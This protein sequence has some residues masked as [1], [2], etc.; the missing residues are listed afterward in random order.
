MKQLFFYILVFVCLVGCRQS[1]PTGYKTTTTEV[2]NSYQADDEIQKLIAPYKDSVD[3]QMN[4]IIGEFSHEMFKAKPEGE[5]GNFMSDAMLFYHNN[6]FLHVNQADFA[7][8]NYGGIRLQH[9]PAGEVSVETMFKLMPFENQMVLVDVPGTVL[10]QIFSRFANDNGWPVSENVHLVIANQQLLSSTVN[11]EKID[12]NKTYKVL[13]SDYVANGGDGMNMLTDLE[14]S[15][16]G[17]KLRDVFIE[18]IKWNNSLGDKIKAP[19]TNRI[20]DKSK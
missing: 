7:F 4:E 13:T 18:Y 20:I 3:Q 11:G 5:L 15:R 1:I 8:T 17:V 14:R 19:I 2:N 12:E 16:V 6:M 9:I 10:L